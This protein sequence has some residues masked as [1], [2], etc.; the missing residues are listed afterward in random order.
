MFIKSISLVF[1]LAF[2]SA[3][4]S[5]ANGADNNAVKGVNKVELG[6]EPLKGKSSEP[7]K[8]KSTDV[9]L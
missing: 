3:N 6:A 1:L 4:A 9:F 7:A 5:A 2:F 8:E